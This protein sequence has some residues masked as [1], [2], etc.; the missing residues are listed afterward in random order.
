MFLR[1]KRRLEPPLKVN[2]IGQCITLLCNG[3]RTRY[4]IEGRSVVG[5]ERV[6]AL[7]VPWEPFAQHI[8][9]A[10]VGLL[11]NVQIESK[12]ETRM[13]LSILY[14]VFMVNKETVE[15]I[16]S[17]ALWPMLVTFA[18][19]ALER[20]CGFFCDGVHTSL[21]PFGHTKSNW[22]LEPAIPRDPYR[23]G[24]ISIAAVHVDRVDA[25]RI[26][27]AQN[28]ESS[29]WA[30]MTTAL[31]PDE[32]PAGCPERVGVYIGRLQY[33][34]RAL[35][36]HRPAQHFDAC[37]TCGRA[38]YWPVDSRGSY[39]G[40]KDSIA[41]GPINELIQ[42]NGALKISNSTEPYWA[43]CGGEL[44]GARC[45][46][47]SLSCQ[48]ELLN[49]VEAAMGIT[50]F[51][52]EHAGLRATPFSSKSLAPH[53]RVAQE[54]KMA[55]RRNEE[56]AKRLA[57]QSCTGFKLLHS[58]DAYVLRQQTIAML[59]VDTALLFLCD[60]L[61]QTKANQ[62]MATPCSYRSYRTNALAYAQPVARVRALYERHSMNND[63][64]LLESGVSVHWVDK[65]RSQS[66]AILGFLLR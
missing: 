13:L 30:D 34:A 40:D 26:V 21:D 48:E 3:D 52:L 58:K 36:L 31:M 46:F 20:E 59:N 28:L 43:R 5:I 51:D 41:T 60:R 25:A 12:Q 14:N 29:N 15:L 23:R 4:H 24:H 17:R 18:N 27:L 47:C 16:S 19:G 57:S 11:N 2:C 54:L 66:S 9:E 33:T 8:Y 50:A 42:T 32:A 1:S 6:N 64:L 61:Y 56:V 7:S 63:P 53:E 55:Y 65:V 45:V 44:P 37:V 49:E 39:C 35:R 10:V 62:K 38:A 22:Q